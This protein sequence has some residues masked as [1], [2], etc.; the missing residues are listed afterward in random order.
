M[1]LFFPITYALARAAVALHND[2]AY[3]NSETNAVSG[4]T[5]TLVDAKDA[6]HKGR[7]ANGSPTGYALEDLN[8]TFR[9][10]GINENLASEMYAK[11]ISPGERT[12]YLDFLYSDPNNPRCPKVPRPTR[13]GEIRDL[14]IAYLVK[15]K[16]IIAHM[17]YYDG[18]DLNYLKEEYTD[19][20]GNLLYVTFDLGKIC[21]PYCPKD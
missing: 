11:N 6:I 10:A 17:T 20:A 7:R 21:P 8:Y 1:L 9:F 19:S 18:T 4:V 5:Q 15:Q 13:D 12:Q 3:K 2:P 14:I 16:T